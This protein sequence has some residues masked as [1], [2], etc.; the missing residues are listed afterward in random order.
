[1]PAV[2]SRVTERRRSG[3]GEGSGATH[4]FLES[5]VEGS[6]RLRVPIQPLPFVVGRGLGVALTLRSESVSKHHAEIYRE[7]DRLRI[8]DLDST[9][10]TFVRRRRIRNAALHDGDIIHFAEFEFRLGREPRARSGQAEERG[11]TPKG[12]S[13]SL[14]HGL[15]RLRAVEELLRDE[16][17]VPLFQPIV[18]LQ[19]KAVTAFAAT[20]RPTHPALADAEEDLFEMAEVVEN[21]SLEIG[22][23]RLIRR[24]A[25]E[26]AVRRG[27]FPALFLNAR[28]SELGE[29]GFAESL[30]SLRLQAPALELTLEIHGSAL[31]N[32][33]GIAELRAH[34]YELHLGLAYD[35]LATT[36]T[37]LLEL[38]DSPP[39][40]IKFDRRLVRR[41][42]LAPRSKRRLLTS[43]VSAAHDLLA[44]TVA[45]GV[46][47]QSEAEVCGEIGFT[48]AQ[49]PFF[50]RPVS[51]EELHDTH[52]AWDPR[53]LDS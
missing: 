24:R 51:I 47:S 44:R 37:R 1:V 3:A 34:L 7:G 27:S 2:V 32:P 30:R 52:T 31:D 4:W 12:R 35:D 43:L 42:D 16:A 14:P 53:W 23:S 13:L 20:A 28:P 29:P 50:G 19:T 22:L 8:R 36:P 9:N 5:L 41:I 33:K 18:S 38:A 6:K 15:E 17:I 45:Q 25:L 21:P 48:H 46:E 10:G 49:G 11:T 39:D 26:Q 40:Y